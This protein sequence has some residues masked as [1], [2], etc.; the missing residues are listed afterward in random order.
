[1]LLDA[2]PADGVSVE[3]PFPNVRNKKPIAK[4]STDVVV[5]V[6]TVISIGGNATAL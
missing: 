3:Q 4:V 6:V 5:M 2:M 1:M